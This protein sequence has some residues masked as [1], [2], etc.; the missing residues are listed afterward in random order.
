MLSYS[1]RIRHG[2]IRKSVE[3]LTELQS[4]YLSI[5]VILSIK[6]DFRKEIWLL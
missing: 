4:S 1:F 6:T 5:K 2:C 3:G